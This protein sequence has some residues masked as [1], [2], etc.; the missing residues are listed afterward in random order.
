[1]WGFY[2]RGCTRSKVES[3]I[4]VD[5][6]HPLPSPAPA[7][8]TVMYS[9]NMMSSVSWA[10]NRFLKSL[11]MD[12][13]R[14]VVRFFLQDRRRDQ[15]LPVPKIEPWNERPLYCFNLETICLWYTKRVSFYT[16]RQGWFPSD[17]HTITI[18]MGS[19]DRQAPFTP[20][21]LRRDPFSLTTAQRAV[22]GIQLHQ[23]TLLFNHYKKLCPS[24]H[25][26]KQTP[27]YRPLPGFFRP[28][29]RQHG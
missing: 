26:P 10:E 28:S 11:P 14:S 27:C 7:G 18:V 4:S 5:M 19:K 22:A 23:P 21:S 15:C 20:E 8:V 12:R 17:P 3:C 13:C 2:N 1:M 16:K 29:Q 6:I 25:S 24:Q 9:T